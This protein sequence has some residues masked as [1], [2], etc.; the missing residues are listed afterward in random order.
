MDD[1]G[2]SDWSFERIR[3]FEIDRACQLESAG[4]RARIAT[5][6]HRARSGAERGAR[7]ARARFSP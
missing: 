7:V 5:A 4:S 2:P 3:E 6:E 1:P